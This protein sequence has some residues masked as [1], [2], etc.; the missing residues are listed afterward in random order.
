MCFFLLS[1]KIFIFEHN[2]VYKKEVKVLRCIL[3]VY[4]EGVE[5]SSLKKCHP[6]IRNIETLMFLIKNNLYEEQLFVIWVCQ[7]DDVI[8]GQ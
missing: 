8:G 7:K 4:L 3:K 6:N 5:G 1:R 2:G